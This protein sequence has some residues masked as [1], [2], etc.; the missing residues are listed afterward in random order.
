MSTPAHREAFGRPVFRACA[1]TLST[2]VF[3]LFVIAHQGQAREW[4][5]ILGGKGKD[6]ALS[7]VGTAD[8]GG[9]VAGHTTSRGAGK[10]DAWVVR[11]DDTGKTLWDRVLGGPKA[12]SV[13]AIRS[14]RDGGYILA[15]STRSGGARQT[16][17]W[18]IKL[19]A[20]GRRQWA[21]I[22][23]GKDYDGFETV[24]PL[25]GGGFLLAGYTRSR[26]AGRQDAW[27][28]K[29][30]AAGRLLWERR[31]GGGG[32]GVINAAVETSNGGYVLVGQRKARTAGAGDGWVARIDR[33]GRLLWSKRFGG[34][35]DDVFAAIAK[36]PS[37]GFAIAGR[38][39]STGAGGYDGWLLMIG[40]DGKQRWARTFGG[41][42]ADGFNAVLAARGG[43]FVLL[44]TT[45]SGRDP[46]GDGWVVWT[47]A[48]GMHRAERR[49]GGTGA[50]AA[51]GLAATAGNGLVLAGATAS[52]TGGGTDGW[53]VR[54]TD[55]V[56]GPTG[57]SR[58][59]PGAHIGERWWL[60][61]G[62]ALALAIAG[63]VGGGACLLLRR[64]RTRAGGAPTEEIVAADPILASTRSGRPG[65]EITLS[66]LVGS[67]ASDWSLLG[68]DES[69]R[70]IRYDFD[71]ADLTRSGDGLVLGR[72]PEHCHFAI[73]NTSISR[74][75][76]RLLL[77]DGHV[78]MEDLDSTNGT[79][80]DGRR[81]AP[82]EPVSLHSGASLIFGDFFLRFVANR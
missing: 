14:S 29:I 59:P 11:F 50:D 71:A 17:G 80:V 39:G 13:S 67:S 16:D 66:A 57:L 72:N 9:V 22:F 68:Y 12:D 25:T 79:Y 78:V 49:F 56:S 4:D 48:S 34:D 54:F 77:S 35:G 23:G 5:R 26:S 18:V 31:F 76:V 19:D 60:W 47:N 61:L 69:G 45:R 40:D 24:V 30:D 43:G 32:D 52:R 74:R 53:I 15:G 75:H 7:V 8:G 73:D 58:S 81:V 63:G 28:V 65:P 37:G 27:V 36:V 51:Y 2:A 42:R 64:R 20:E 70:T 1:V 82:R 21:R 33:A 44:G 62:G 46:A 6:V 10:A 55:P 38:T 41:A 3:A